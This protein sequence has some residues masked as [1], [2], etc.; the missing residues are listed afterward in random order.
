MALGIEGRF[1]FRQQLSPQQ[2]KIT[3]AQDQQDSL[4]RNAGLLLLLL[5][6]RLLKAL[7]QVCAI[8][9]LQ[10][11]CASLLKLPLLF[12]KLGFPGLTQLLVLLLNCH[13]RRHQRFESEGWRHLVCEVDV[14]A[15]C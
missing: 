5:L 3:A 11:L 10:N 6:L 4:L 15:A 8:P 2:A 13:L 14:V 1:H 9:W 7:L 12:F